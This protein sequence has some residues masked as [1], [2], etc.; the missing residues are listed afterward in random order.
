MIDTIHEH[1]LYLHTRFDRLQTFMKRY[2]LLSVMAVFFDHVN[3]RMY[4]VRYG[5]N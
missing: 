5:T 4:T 1:E 3:A 2:S